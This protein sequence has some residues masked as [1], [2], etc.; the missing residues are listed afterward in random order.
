[1]LLLTSSVSMVHLLQ[2]VNNIDNLLLTEICSV[3]FGCHCFF[4]FLLAVQFPRLPLFLRTLTIL[5]SIDHVIFRMLLN[6]ELPDV[7]LISRLELESCDEDQ[8][9]KV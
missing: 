2:L 7:F 9:G 1:M 8:H 6:L 3:L 5:R 4:R